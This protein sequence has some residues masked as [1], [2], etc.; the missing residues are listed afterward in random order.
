MEFRVAADT[1]IGRDEF[2]DVID[3]DFVEDTLGDTSEIP[4]LLL[5]TPTHLEVSYVSGTT[6]ELR[7]KPPDGK[8][9]NLSY[10]VSYWSK[11]DFSKA[12]EMTTE[13]TTCL[14]YLK[15]ETTYLF[16]VS[17]PNTAKRSNLRLRK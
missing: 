7:W 6:A 5:Q 8:Q 17:I 1:C 2:S 11:E 4:K 9:S 3:T 14:Y 13:Y 12:D 16:N 10:H 15:P